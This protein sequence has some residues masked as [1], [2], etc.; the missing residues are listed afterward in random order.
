MRTLTTALNGYR[1]HR[2]AW[3]F[4]SLLATLG[5]GPLFETLVPGFD[6]LELLLAVNLLAA[7]GSAWHERWFRLLLLLGAAFVAARGTQ[8]LLGI[9]LL[10]PASQFLWVSAGLLAM[11]T[12]LRHALRTG[13]VNAER[14]FAALDAYLLAGLMFG[15]CYWL[16]DQ[17]WP[18]SFGRELE[19][20]LS[21]AHAIYFSFVTIATLG[22]G[23]IVPASN[24]AQ[25][26]AIL[27]AV[28]GQLY[29]AVLVARLVSL[30]A[31]P[32]DD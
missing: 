8:A 7:I 23:D 16:I 1:R 9:M 17:S 22:Y 24:F 11:I 21:L 18:A 10:I 27:E 20:G 14:I 25:G 13:T 31:R 12:A 4:F 29:V 32:A 19:G 26:L 2:F 28:S 5:L 6:L 15:V 30:F 3:L